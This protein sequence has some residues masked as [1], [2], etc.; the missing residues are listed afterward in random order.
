MAGKQARSP[1]PRLES[2]AL[3]S[4]TSISRGGEIVS[5]LARTLHT[6][7]AADVSRRHL[8]GEQNA[9]TDVG[10]YTL[11]ANRAE[12]EISGLASLLLTTPATEESPGKLLARSRRAGIQPETVPRAPKHTLDCLRHSTGSAADPFPVPKL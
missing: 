1:A 5:P 10:G 3:Y 7:V 9:P 4:Y 11:S 6:R 8:V 2:D 12:G